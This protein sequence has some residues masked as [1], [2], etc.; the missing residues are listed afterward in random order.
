MFL[1]LNTMLATLSE[2]EL[3]RCNTGRRTSVRVTVI[4]EFMDLLYLL[5]E[6][7]CLCVRI[8]F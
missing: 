5:V 1:H 2:I 3:I 7:E 4:N 8:V 6:R